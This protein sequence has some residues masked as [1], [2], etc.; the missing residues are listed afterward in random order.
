MPR[1]NALL[2]RW[3]LRILIYFTQ[4][5]LFSGCYS[6]PLA[7]EH[8]GA[9]SSW[10]YEFRGKRI[11][12]EP[13]PQHL[14]VRYK[15][16]QGADLERRVFTTTHGEVVAR[17]RVVTRG[18]TLLSAEGTQPSIQGVDEVRL[19]LLN[20]P[21]VLWVYPAFIHSPSGQVLLLTNEI[22][23]KVR[24]GVDAASL[25]LFLPDG[26]RLVRPLLY[27]EDEFI[28]ELTNPKA[29]DPLAIANSFVETQPW[30]EWAQPN[31]IREYVR[32]P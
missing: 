31:F 30:V 11:S 6:F 23:L 24:P 32:W 28:L 7:V 4:L 3:L 25:P 19:Q 21:D 17:L 20:S 16:P 15:T 12:I 14:S 26:V 9:V 5:G 1:P 27:A 8:K 13:S 22:L 10:Y 29:A 2:A 18:V